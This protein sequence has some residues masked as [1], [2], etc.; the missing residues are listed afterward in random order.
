[1]LLAATLGGFL[2]YLE[3]YWAN[4]AAGLVRLLQT[5]DIARVPGLVE[6][7]KPYRS[8]ANALLEEEHKKAAPE[9]REELNTAIALLPVQPG[10]AEYL[11]GRVL[12][13]EL[14]FGQLPK[15]NVVRV[16]LDSAARH[17]PQIEHR[18]RILMRLEA[19]VSA[20]SRPD[21]KEDVKE[22]EAKTKAKAAVALLRM[23]QPEKVWPLLKHSADPR[24]R[25]YLLHL[26]GPAGVDFK[27][28]RQQL[29]LQSD[30]SIRRAL[31]LSLG[32]FS[33]ED[34]AADERDALVN[35]LCVWYVHDADSG[36]HAGI[37]WLLGQWKHGQWLKKTN[38]QWASQKPWREERLDSI[39]RGLAKAGPE[40]LI[41]QW[42][43]NSQGQTM[44]VI[45]SSVEFMI[46]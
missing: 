13:A 7:L 1:L 35:D 2:A 3:T 14:D 43:I 16:I 36:L 40:H 19:E 10:Q 45:P 46:G 11:Y 4:H 32:E 8:W 23:D 31:L 27:V 6:E 30:V 29:K 33:E 9:S 17:P 21:A 34:I 12:D 24:V 41:S 20:R 42:Y 44:V 39:R 38:D 28:I 15:P 18:R 25:S 5:A 26:L 37:E 22:K